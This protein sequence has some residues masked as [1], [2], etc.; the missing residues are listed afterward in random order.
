MGRRDV[1]KAEARR[2]SDVTGRLRTSNRVF[3]AAARSYAQAVPILKQKNV[4]SGSGR[5][6]SVQ[7][8]PASGRVSVTRL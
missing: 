6:S 5:G 1:R 2:V 7:E 4:P 3:E 8:K